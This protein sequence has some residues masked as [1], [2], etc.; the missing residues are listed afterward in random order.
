VGADGFDFVTDLDAIMPM[1]VIGMLPG[2]PEFVTEAVR[3]QV[4]ATC[5]LKTEK[6]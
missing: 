2:I 4:D 5:A 1:R 3:Q 6:R